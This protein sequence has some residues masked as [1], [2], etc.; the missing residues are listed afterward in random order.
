MFIAQPR[1]RE[2]AVPNAPGRNSPAISRF[3]NSTGQR[4]AGTN[5]HDRNARRGF[6][7]YATDQESRKHEPALLRNETSF[8]YSTFNAL[9]YLALKVWRS[10]PDHHPYD[11]EKSGRNLDP[12]VRDRLRVCAAA[13]KCVMIII[14]RPCQPSSPVGAPGSTCGPLMLGSIIGLVLGLALVTEKL[15]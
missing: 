10:N 9:T 14:Y 3:Q 2:P 11:L 7:G 6:A 5:D 15:D 8:Y 1:T 4:R 13:R 12:A